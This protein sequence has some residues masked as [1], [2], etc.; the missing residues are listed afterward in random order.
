MFFTKKWVLALIA[1]IFLLAVFM[2]Q[3][4]MHVPVK[5]FVG[6]PFHIYLS[7]IIGASML[8]GAVLTIAG[9]MIFK[10]IQSKLRKKRSEDEIT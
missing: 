5:L 10:Q 3:N 9:I 2:D 8:T 1:F 4:T 6:E 7:L